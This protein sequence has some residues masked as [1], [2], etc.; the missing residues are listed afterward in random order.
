MK[1]F[2][3]PN[4][5]PYK[6]KSEKEKTLHIQKLGNIRKSTFFCPNLMKLDENNYLVN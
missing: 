4:A 1:V 3:W 6:V 2:N 5:V